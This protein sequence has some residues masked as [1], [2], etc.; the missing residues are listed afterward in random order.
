MLMPMRMRMLMRLLLRNA[1]GL[2]VFANNQLYLG[3]DVGKERGLS[4]LHRFP[5]SVV[6]NALTTGC[7]GLYRGG[8][9]VS[10]NVTS[11]ADRQKDRWVDG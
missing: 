4:V 9:L 3:G 5:P 11:Q 2:E 7:E 8:D 10:S 1:Q 6:P